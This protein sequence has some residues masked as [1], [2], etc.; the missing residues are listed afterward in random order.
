MNNKIL[1]MLAYVTLIGWLIAFFVKREETDSL[2]RYHLRQGL[3]LFVVAFVLNFISYILVTLSAS[4]SFLGG[5][6][7]L[8]VLIFS[9]IGILNA[10]KEE[11]KPL[12]IFGKRFEDQFN[13]L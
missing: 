9:I 4:L 11:E 7:G 6:V 12:P 8:V 13:F 10:S 5:F 2:R 1:A 3:G